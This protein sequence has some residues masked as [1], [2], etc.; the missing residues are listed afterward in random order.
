MD[1]AIDHQEQEDVAAHR[2]LSAWL[3]KPWFAKLWWTTIPVW[4]LGMAVSTRVD[5]L[6]SF[7]RGWIAG[8]LNV[9]FFPMTALMVLGVGY[10]RERLDSF[11]GQ[12]DDVPL[13]DEEAS[14]LAAKLHRDQLERMRERARAYANPMDPRSGSLWI[15]SA[16]N[17]NNPAYIDPNGR[18]HH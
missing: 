3:W 8:Y 5:T 2:D 13:S 11:V 16:M 15:G 14:A 17:P 7:Y 12:G 4:W 10:V 9:V 6:E 18:K 1:K